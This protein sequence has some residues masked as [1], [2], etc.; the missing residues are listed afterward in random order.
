MALMPLLA[1]S[2]GR[3]PEVRALACAPRRMT[4]MCVRPS[5]EARRR[6]LAPQDDG[7]I[8]CG[9]L[10]ASSPSLPRRDDLDLVAGLKRRLGPAALRQHVVIQRDREMR[11]LIFEFSEQRVDPCRRYLPLLAID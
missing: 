1:P 2:R 10:Q 11:A 7:G 5:F 4:V 6:R 9:I 3:H 8:C